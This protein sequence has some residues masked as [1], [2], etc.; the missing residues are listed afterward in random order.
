[1]F[2]FKRAERADGDMKKAP[3]AHLGTGTVVLPH[4]A[5]LM[6]AGGSEEPNK[7]AVTSA[8]AE[9]R[10][11]YSLLAQKAQ[12]AKGRGWAACQG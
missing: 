12:I 5:W 1:V 10:A 11:D 3:M 8:T 9:N 6:P 4:A 7:L 2:T